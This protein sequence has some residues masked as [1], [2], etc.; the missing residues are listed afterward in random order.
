MKKRLTRQESRALTQEKLLQSAARIIARKGF[1]G[2]SIEEIAENAGFSRGAFHSNYKSKDALFLELVE[3]QVKSLTASIHAT[4]KVAQAP[5]ETLKHLGDA[6]SYYSGADKDAFLLLT[7]AQ[8][9][10][11]RNPRFGKK[12]NALFDGIYSDLIDAVN[13]FQQQLGIEDP[14]FAQ[15]MVLIGFALSHGFALHNL[16]NPEKFSDQMVSKSLQFVYERFF[17]K[18]QA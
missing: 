16:M 4:L 2:A 13:S 11:L 8:L 12:L 1:A 15:R 18:D 5:E 14:E 7:E 6:Y 9:F 10:A 3:K 17:N